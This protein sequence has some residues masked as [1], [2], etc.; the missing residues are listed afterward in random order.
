MALVPGSPSTEVSQSQHYSSP[1]RSS[2]TRRSLASIVVKSVSFST[3]SPT[4]QPSWSFGTRS[5]GTSKD[6]TPF[7]P[8]RSAFTTMGSGIGKTC[9]GPS[10]SVTPRESNPPSVLR[11]ALR[12]TPTRSSSSWAFS[13]WWKRWRVDHGRKSRLCL[14][15][16]AL[17]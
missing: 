16:S 3:P 4:I 13:Q 17:G 2:G 10:S 6:L 12:G 15:C 8:Q 14:T 7:W 9:S 1:A 5:T 11:P